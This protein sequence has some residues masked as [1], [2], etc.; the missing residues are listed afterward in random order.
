M[1]DVRVLVCI[2]R[3]EQL[4]VDAPVYLQG[5]K[6]KTLPGPSSKKNI[7]CTVY[8]PTLKLTVTEGCQWASEKKLRRINLKHAPSSRLRYCMPSAPDKERES[9]QQGSITM[10]LSLQVIPDQKSEYSNTIPSVL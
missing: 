3:E 5:L 10:I 4:K 6:P 2:L 8:T 7:S 9:A 1:S